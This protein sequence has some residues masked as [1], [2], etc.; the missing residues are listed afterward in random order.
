MLSSDILEQQFGPTKVIII[1][2]NSYIR[3]INTVVAD[4]GQVLELSMV[5]FDASGANKY[6]HIHANIV[7][8]ESIG[9]AFRAA[10]VEFIRKTQYQTTSSLPDK[11]QKQFG[12]KGMPTIV[13]VSIFVGKPQIHYCDIFEIY[14]PLVKWPSARDDVVNVQPNIEL[15]LSSI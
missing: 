4:R 2:Q 3:V 11:I 8:G 13:G 5:R 15:L 9:K 6:S 1:K 14:S 10:G 7:A 12:V